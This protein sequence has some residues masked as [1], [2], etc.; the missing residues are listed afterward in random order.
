M[1]FNKCFVSVAKILFIIVPLWIAVEHFAHD[2]QPIARGM[3]MP[4]YDHIAGPTLED[5]PPKVWI[6]GSAEPVL[7]YVSRVTRTVHYATYHC[8]PEDN[9][10][11]WIGT[12]GNEAA[13]LFGYDTAYELGLFRFSTL[14][15]GYC[16]ER[17][18]AVTRTLRENGIDSST[19]GLGG[20]VVTQVVIDGK[21]YFTDPDYGV[22]PYPSDLGFDSIQEKY[23]YSVLPSNAKLVATIV[24]ESSGG[25]P[26]FTDEYFDSLRQLRRLLHYASNALASGLIALSVFATYF[27]WLR[28]LRVRRK[29]GANPGSPAPQAAT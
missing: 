7:A 23:K 24:S 8:L 14:R 3:D 13:K 19:Y 5:I 22:G 10:L 11:S 9:S 26:Y 16:S 18:A 21:T 17:A 2:M 28:R 15:C 27:F 25:V 6:R 1:M 20:H 12:V 4:G 29:F